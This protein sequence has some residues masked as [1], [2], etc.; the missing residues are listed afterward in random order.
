MLSRSTL[1]ITQENIEQIIHYETPA[2]FLRKYYRSIDFGKCE[3]SQE[4]MSYLGYCTEVY[5]KYE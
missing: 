1:S 5:A 3:L 4:Y 2:S